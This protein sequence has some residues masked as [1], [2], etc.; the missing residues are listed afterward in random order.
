[1]GQRH[2]A[3]EL[4]L[5]CVYAYDSVG[6]DVNTICESIIAN[7]KLGEES[8]KFA[9]TLFRKIV[10]SLDR[11][12]QEITSHSQNWQIERLAMVDKNILRMAICELLCFPDI[13]ARAT[14]NEAVELAKR[15][16]TLESSKFVNGILDAVYRKHQA[17]ETREPDI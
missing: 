1:M 11:I 8:M 7:A 4:A 9:E 16:S 13:P 17:Q 12:D 14:I 3:R 10:A 2:K 15:Y 6:Q 5:K